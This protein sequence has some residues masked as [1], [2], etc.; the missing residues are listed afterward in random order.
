MTVGTGIGAAAVVGGRPASGLGHAEMG[1]IA[2]PRQPGDTYPGGCP[3]HGDC[4]EGMAA[5]GAIAARF[6]RPGEQL[7]GDDLRQARRVGGRLPRRGAAHDRLHDR[8]RAHR[9]RRERG[10][11]AGAVPAGAG[12]AD[13]DDGRLRRRCPSTLRTTS[14]C[15]RASA[16]WPG[17]R[18]PWC[19]PRTRCSPMNAQDTAQTG[20]ADGARP[21]GARPGG[22]RRR[23]ARRTGRRG[24][25]GRRR[26]GAAVVAGRG[27][28]LRHR[29]ADDGRPVP[30]HRPGTAR[31]IDAGFA[32]FVKVVQ[33]WSRSP[34][35][36]FIPETMREFALAALPFEAEPRVYRSD[37]ADRL[38]PGLTMPRAY[39]V[40]DLDPESTALWL[41]HVP[42]VAARWDRTA[43]SR[44][45]TCSAGS[46]RARRCARW[47]R[48]P[49][50][51]G[52]ARSAATRRAASSCK[53]VARPARRRASGAHPVVAAAFDDAAAPRPR[54][55][56]RRAPG[57]R[58]RAGGP[59]ARRR[60][61]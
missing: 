22:R 19:W 52:A 26:G 15:R 20:R 12:E 38:P 5:G 51:D 16:G 6:G 55:R 14:W 30:G 17:P 36:A 18:A 24:A 4:L 56:R 47:R 48:S 13:R 40:V 57:A 60:A 11:A 58:R 25:R 53:V 8:P 31:D 29:G 46:P 54:R 42:V 61:R 3:Y 1:H 45:A 49:T 50:P 28:R 43:L 39:A 41:D 9:D 33:S 32:F 34:T 37:L 35:F 59:A 7:D 27:G 10:G 23:P 2:V 21:V 44:A